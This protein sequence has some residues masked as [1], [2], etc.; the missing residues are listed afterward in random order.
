MKSELQG[1]RLTWL[2]H[3]FRVPNNRYCKK[4]LFGEV[5]GLRLPGRPRSS[6]NAVAIV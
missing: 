6:L 1:K 4:L 5:K 2:G 3:A